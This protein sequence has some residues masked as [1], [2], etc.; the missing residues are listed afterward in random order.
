M[1]EIKITALAKD[2]KGRHIAE[3]LLEIRIT[4]TIIYCKYTQKNTWRYKLWKL[5]Q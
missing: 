5:T 1:L 2:R 3:K 4:G